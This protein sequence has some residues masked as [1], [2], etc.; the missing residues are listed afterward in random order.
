MRQKMRLVNR[1]VKEVREKG[2]VVSSK[3]YV[4]EPGLSQISLAP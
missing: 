4:P 2:G 1:F 3:G